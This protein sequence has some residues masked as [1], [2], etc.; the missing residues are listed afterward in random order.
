MR[1]TKRQLKR[2][3]R[4]E[5]SKL[6]QRPLN[7]AVYLHDILAD[8]AVALNRRDVEAL[9]RLK[10]KFDEM[11]MDANEARGYKMAL[12]A[13]IDAAY[14]IKDSYDIGMR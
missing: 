9:E 10:T 3:I 4:E 13:M 7:E 11:P 12:Q 1:I 14:M 5:T 8:A 2:I 6:R